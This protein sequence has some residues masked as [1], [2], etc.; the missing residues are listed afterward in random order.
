M[1]EDPAAPRRSLSPTTAP[2]IAASKRARGRDAVERGQADHTA[3]SGSTTFHTSSPPT[4][5]R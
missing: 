3:K 4:P 1:G 5:A 2:A